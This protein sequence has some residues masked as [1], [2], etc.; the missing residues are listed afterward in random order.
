MRRIRASAAALAA[1]VLSGCAGEEIL[2][3]LAEP[4]ANEVVVALD[5]AAINNI[6]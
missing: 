6:H 4:Q 5:E 2:H 3:G 1:V